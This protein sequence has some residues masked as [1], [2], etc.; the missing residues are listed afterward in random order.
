[1]GE[2][3]DLGGIIRVDILM[4]NMEL[5]C[6][7]GDCLVNAFVFVKISFRI[8]WRRL[9]L[10]VYCTECAIFA[11]GDQQGTGPVAL[12]YRISNHPR[13][14][15]VAHVLVFCINLNDDSILHTA[16]LMGFFG[17]DVEYLV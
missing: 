6:S 13:F 7:D 8:L 15:I 2:G 17:R 4:N 3:E 16:S 9:S 12:L 14:M 1:M 10:Y 11:V 5:C